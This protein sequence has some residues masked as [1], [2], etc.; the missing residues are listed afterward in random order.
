MLEVEW[1][2]NEP[3]DLLRRGGV[4]GVMPPSVI[5]EWELPAADRLS[6]KAY[7]LPPERSDGLMGVAGDYQDGIQ[8]DYHDEETTLYQIGYFGAAR[9]GVMRTGAVL[10]FPV[11]REVHPQLAAIHSTRL[12]SQMVN[13]SGVH[14]VDAAW[15][16][17]LLLPVLAKLQILAGRAENEEWKSATPPARRATFARLLRRGKGS[18]SNDTGP[19]FRRWIR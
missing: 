4:G 18:M 6:L 3:L 10:T 11:I 7:G 13:S 12:P 2:L 5:D 19:L 15:R 16:W 14:F 9:L 8:P 1:I 17:H